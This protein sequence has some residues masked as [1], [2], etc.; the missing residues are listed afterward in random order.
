MFTIN[1][2]QLAK[3]LALLQSAA[4]PK[5]TIPI[6]SF[7]KFEVADGHAQLT[8]SD[9]AITLSVEIEAAGEWQGCIPMKQLV[10]LVRLFTEDE[11][12]FTP[13]P[14]SRIEV[15]GA[16]SKHLLVTLPVDDFPD[17]EAASGETITIPA[18]QL[19]QALTRVAFCAG[20]A[21]EG[22]QYVFECVVMEVVNRML[23]ITATNSKQLG[24]V[25]MAVDSDAQVNAL[26]PLRAVEGLIKLCDGEGNIE[27][28]ADENHAQFKRGSQTLVTRLVVGNFPNWRLVV[29]DSHNYRTLL[30]PERLAL[31]IKRA[32][33]TT[34]ETKMIRHPLNLAF[35][36]DQ[37]SIASS[38]EDGESS[39]ELP[40]DCAA[41]NGDDLAIRINGEH[42]LKFLGN[43]EAKVNCQFSDDKRM[44]QFG[45]EGDA[46][47][48]YI[49]M[50]LR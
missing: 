17:P 47:Y 1:R 18:S 7:I 10:N 33:V 25:S 49:T 24:T 46:S 31:A 34:R 50:A 8:A 40:I 4:E 14:N 28:L 23:A 35:S 48:L 20:Q 38:S 27:F 13:K 45:L 11:I 37:L 9:Q 41:L 6:L 39:D 12:K 22:L 29:P 16:T 21:N 2:S 26:V 44:L 42:V 15:K 19:L 3:E 43:A 30:D 36:K 5:G 32:C